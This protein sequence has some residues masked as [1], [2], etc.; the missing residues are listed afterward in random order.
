[1]P[2]RSV[3]ARERAEAQ[4]VLAKPLELGIDHGI[5]AVCGEH[6]SLPAG[7]TELPVMIE[8]VERRLGSRD[9]LDVEALEQRAGTELRSRETRIDVIERAVGGFGR[10]PFGAAEYRRERVVEPDPRR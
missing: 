7:G 6:A 8:R 10:E 2:R 5:G 9:H 3:F 1:P 4:H